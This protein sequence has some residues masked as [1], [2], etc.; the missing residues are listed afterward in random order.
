LNGVVTVYDATPV[1]LS[2]TTDNDLYQGDQNGDVILTITGHNLGASSQFIFC[3]SGGTCDP[4][5]NST[6]DIG[7]YIPL[8]GASEDTVQM[9]L[10]ASANALGSY[11]VA[12]IS[13][14]VGG[15]G[16]FAAQ[17]TSNKKQAPG[18]N[19]LGSPQMSCPSVVRGAKPGGGQSRSQRG[20][21]PV[22]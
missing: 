20:R 4:N 6:S 17:N 2:A 5:T 13:D 21:G 9:V 16:F 19:V 22:G 7:F 12:V 3:H 11:D 1:I 10:T 14:G 15:S 18:P 8:G